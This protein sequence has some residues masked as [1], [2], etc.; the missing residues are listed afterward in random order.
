MPLLHRFTTALLLAGLLISSVCRADALH[1]EEPWAR[2]TAAGA[3]VGVAYLT[4]RNEGEADRL[5]GASSPASASVEIHNMLMQDGRMQM[6]PVAILEIPANSTVQ[7]APGGLHLML[8]NLHAPLVEGQLVE[9]TLTFEKA[10]ARTVKASIAGLGATRPD[11][12]SHHH[13]H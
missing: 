6:R 1:I 4:L 9:L 2:A 5:L 8:L 10:G 11:H 7:L 12:S 3:Q 13:H